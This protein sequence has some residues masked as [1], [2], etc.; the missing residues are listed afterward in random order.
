ML[1][2]TINHCK[3]NPDALW[4]KQMQPVTVCPSDCD[5]VGVRPW[6]IVRCHPQ[7]LLPV[8]L[9]ISLLADTYSPSYEKIGKTGVLQRPLFPGYLFAKFYEE[10]Q[11]SIL[12]GIFG[13]LRT[14][15]LLRF[16][17]YSEPET[18]TDHEI[19][20]VRRWVSAG[21]E[22]TEV[23]QARSGDYVE[24]PCGIRGTLMRD[25]S[26]WYVVTDILLRAVRVRVD[27]PNSVRLLDI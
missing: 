25:G 24:G 8:R 15:P 16:G 14:Q 19:D 3:T 7:H 22:P 18:M 21:A 17:A 9:R 23:R 26:H 10:P 1:K 13:I 20:D 4:F 11:P 27:G 12:S 6:H 2:P 5:A